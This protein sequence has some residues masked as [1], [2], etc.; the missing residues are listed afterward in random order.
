MWLLLCRAAHRAGHSAAAHPSSR[1]ALGSHKVAATPADSDLLGLMHGRGNRERRDS[2]TRD[3]LEDRRAHQERLSTDEVVARVPAAL[4]KSLEK[5]GLGSKKRKGQVYRSNSFGSSLD[6]ANTTGAG[7]VAVHLTS[8]AGTPEWP[9]FEHILPE[10]AFAGH[11]NCGK[12]TLVNAM[13]GLQPRRGPASVSDR[14]G[15]TDLVCFYQLGKKPPVLVLADMPG[16]G[17]AVASALDKKAWRLMVKDYLRRR[18]VLARCCLLVDCTRGLCDDDRHFLLFLHKLRVDWQVRWVWAGGLL[19]LLPLDSSRESS[20]LSPSLP[21]SLPFF[22]LAHS[23][24]PL[25]STLPSPPPTHPPNP[26]PAHHPRQCCRL[27]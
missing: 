17:H 5:L 22:Q 26:P 20:A 4:V 1:R 8:A 13:A 24:S 2:V 14:A 25:P 3:M 16:Y 21:P 15:W 10:V 11:S 9:V 27:C 12:S 19:L 6:R 7:G 23:F 18:P